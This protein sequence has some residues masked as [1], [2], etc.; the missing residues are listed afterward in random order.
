MRVD[1]NCYYISEWYKDRGIENGWFKAKN[2]FITY[3]H[4]NS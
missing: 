4:Y 3:V 2:C 1:I